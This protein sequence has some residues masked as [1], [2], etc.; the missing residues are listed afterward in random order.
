M[1]VDTFAPTAP[2][3]ISGTGPY[4]VTHSFSDST[5]ILVSVRN[6]GVD[7]PLT[8]ITDFTVSPTGPA[9]AGTVTLTAPAAA[10]HA[11]RTLLVARA[12]VAEQGWV[13]GNAREQA[14][15]EQ[16][17]RTI[18]AVQDVSEKAGR[19]LRIAPHTAG[20]GEIVPLAGAVLSW[21][22]DGKLVNGPVLTDISIVAGISD[23]IDAV[24]A[25]AANVTTVAG[26]IEDV[27]TVA[28]IAANVSIV[29]GV[30]D[31]VTAV[32]ML[33]TQGRQ[34]ATRAAFLADTGYA[35]AA[36]VVV[37]ASG[38]SY[39]RTTGATAI[40]DLLGWLPFGYFTPDHFAE[41]VT[42]GTTNMSAA[43]QAAGDALGA[44][45]GTDS[46]ADLLPGLEL[47][48][49]PTK[50]YMASGVSWD[51]GHDRLT[52]RG[53]GAWV[54]TDLNGP[55]ISIGDA[56]WFDGLGTGGGVHYNAHITGFVFRN[57]NTAAAASVAIRLGRTDNWTIENNEFWNFWVSVDLFAASTGYLNRNVGKI[58]SR[59]VDALAFFRCQ[60][61]PTPGPASRSGGGFHIFQNEIDGD[62]AD[63][64]RLT[65]GFLIQ[66]VDG[67]YYGS[68]HMKNYLNGFTTQPQ[69]NTTNNVITDIYSYGGN[70]FDEP[71][72][73]GRSV[74]HVG[75]VRYLGDGGQSNG[76]YQNIN[77][78]DGDF[79]RGAGDA[80][81]G[82]V[83]TVTDGGGW[84]AARGGITGLSISGCNFGTQVSA[85]ISISGPQTSATLVPVIRPKITN[86]NFYDGRVGGIVDNGTSYI[87]IEGDGCEITGNTFS[88]EVVAPKRSVSINTV[89]FTDADIV[90]AHNSL[91][92]VN[93]TE[94][95]YLITKDADAIWIIGPNNTPDG[96]VDDNGQNLIT[97]ADDAVGLVTLPVGRF[98][99]I[100]VVHA[101]DTFGGVQN[102]HAGM[103][104]IDAG[105]TPGVLGVQAGAN[106]VI[107]SATLTGTTGTDGRTTISPNA[108]R[109]L[110]IENR[111]GLTMIYRVV[112][113]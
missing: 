57:T 16:L 98:D 22:D 105:S 108:T 52:L 109:Q 99:A 88:A 64:D 54:T 28:G 19:A 47:H 48:F 59:S 112:F 17:D 102:S 74:Q 4:T 60:S 73:G 104:R 100:A 65:H 83:V 44:I 40:A 62:A 96:R 76:Q 30:A 33:I 94:V 92:N 24:A 43:V 6:G 90:F 27:S 103:T 61:V 66:S 3:T 14:L 82:I 77:W 10:T 7:T 9:D 35:P 107:S 84:V 38:V 46:S 72:E 67:L 63:R 91:A 80:D 36:G 56:G 34:Y 13:G 23:E 113:L 53:N 39:V 15:E 87:R 12:T 89:G 11:G 97:I 69:G 41:N 5:E 81:F 86:C 50:Y 25:I 21:D 2:Y 49:R 78:S 68:N 45:I 71:A 58:R 110:Q 70:Y 75:T 31:D 101:Q 111:S 18:R 37:T 8:A 29:A 42:P 32:A 93:V 106:Y 95:P 85:A 79:F 26:E 55:L 20:G 1:T 51:A